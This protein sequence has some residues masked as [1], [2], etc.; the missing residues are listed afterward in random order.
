LRTFIGEEID[1]DRKE[2]IRKD[3]QFINRRILITKSEL[4]GKRLGTLKLRNLYGVI[5]QG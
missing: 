4:N 1:M 5:L 2:W 3:S